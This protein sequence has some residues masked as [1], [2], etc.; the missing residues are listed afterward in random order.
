VFFSGSE[1][2]FA[3]GLVAVGRSPRSCAQ[4]CPRAARDLAR[5]VYCSIL[6]VYKLLSQVGPLPWLSAVPACCA[7]ASWLPAEGEEG[8]RER[9]RERGSEGARERG[10][11]GA[12]ERGSEGGSE[13]A[14]EEGRAGSTGYSKP[15]PPC[16]LLSLCSP[17]LSSLVRSKLQPLAASSLLDIKDVDDTFSYQA[18]NAKGRTV[19]TRHHLCWQVGSN[20]AAAAAAAAVSA[21]AAGI[22][23]AG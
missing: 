6:L 1:L 2:T 4:P 21:A 19:S 22:L 16:V 3:L 7:Y 10:S 15:V 20:A 17:L 13:R 5:P 8:A 14:S 18:A 23:P 12:R 9:G 11:E